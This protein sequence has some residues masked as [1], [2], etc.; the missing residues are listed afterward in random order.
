MNGYAGIE[1]WYHDFVATDHSP[2]LPDMKEMNSA[3]S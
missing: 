2:A 1:R 3:I